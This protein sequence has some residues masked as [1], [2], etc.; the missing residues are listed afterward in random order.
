MNVKSIGGASYMLTFTD[1][2]TRYT[3]AYFL[4]S[5]DEITGKFLEYK[6]FV[7]KQTGK[8]I[9]V[10]R[11]DNGTEYVNARMNN[12]LKV[13]GICHERTVPY[14]PE[15]NGVSERLNRTLVEKARTMLIEAGLPLEYWAEAAA[16]ATYLKNR[17]PTKALKKK[18]HL[19][20]GQE[21]GLIWLI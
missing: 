21:R 15:Q 7:E 18:L 6:A 14:S 5:K 12:I 11:T 8:E 9:K 19:R 4:Q 17:S 2:Y 3:T 10:L 16:T 1:D 20:H 13:N